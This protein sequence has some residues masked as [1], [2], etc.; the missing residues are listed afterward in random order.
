[1]YTSSHVCFKRFRRSS[2]I[3]QSGRYLS[4]AS[5]LI[6]P[7]PSSL[8]AAVLAVVK[9]RVNTTSTGK[10]IGE[11]DDYTCA[12]LEGQ[13]LVTWT[14]L[15]VMFLV[16]KMMFLL[17]I[18]ILKIAGFFLPFDTDT[19]KLLAPYLSEFTMCDGDE[20]YKSSS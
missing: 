11:D 8:P 20:I 15:L 12:L 10:D 5:F 3:L 6:P 17:W 7:F 14:L 1:M 9:S 16:S 4:I 19:I 18:C 2:R 13:F